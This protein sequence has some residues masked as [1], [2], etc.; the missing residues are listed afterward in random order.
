MA[1]RTIPA[2]QQPDIAMLNEHLG[3]LPQ[4]LPAMLSEIEQ[5]DTATASH[6]WRVV[7][8]TRALAEA[9]GIHREIVDHVGIA[10]ALHDIG[11]LDIPD[12]ILMKPG[13]LTDEEFGIIKTHP[14]RGYDRLHSMGITH[15]IVLNLVRWHHERVDGKG[16][17]DGLGGD[18]IP[19]GPRFFSVIDTFDAL[20]SVR[21]Y[22]HEIGE[23]AAERAIEELRRGIGTR[24]CTDAVE[25]F[26]DLY[27]TGR[28]GWILHHF[29]DSN[30]APAFSLPA[31]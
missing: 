12:A 1:Y 21:P 18:Q 5:K 20:T 3:D 14:V 8:Y 22:R 9:L 10:A 31:R 2:D 23:D 27:H 17:P 15:P 4:R 30:P 13:P 24:Y 26:A 6:T 25:A 19:L 16:Y 29:N 11:K 7:L 28:L